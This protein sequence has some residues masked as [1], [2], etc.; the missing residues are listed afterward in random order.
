MRFLVLVAIV[1]ATLTA[2]QSA[3]FGGGVDGTWISSDGVLVSTFSQGAFTS[4][5]TT[6]GETVVED[7]RYSRTGDK[8]TLAWTSLVANQRRSAECTVNS[9]TV[10][11]CTPSQGDAFTL[12]RTAA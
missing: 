9:P 4:R 1:A 2:C 11:S 12:T 8:L 10:M 3:R 6:T 7:G 5:V